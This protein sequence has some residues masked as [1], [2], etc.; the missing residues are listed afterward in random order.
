[1]DKDISIKKLWNKNFIT[2]VIGMEFS[3]IAL[4]RFVVRLYILLKMENPA[5]IGMV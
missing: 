5:L 4:L 1:M 2:F 3:L